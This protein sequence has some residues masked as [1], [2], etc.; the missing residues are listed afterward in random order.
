MSSPAGTPTTN[1]SPE[2]T[3]I[4]DDDK[5]QDLIALF[6]SEFGASTKSKCFMPEHAAFHAT[7]R[8]ASICLYLLTSECNTLLL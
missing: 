2:A 8:D 1:V 7:A 3:P 6:V 5:P 4:N